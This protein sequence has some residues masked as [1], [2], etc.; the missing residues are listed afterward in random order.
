VQAELSTC[1]ERAEAAAA[2]SIGSMFD[3]VFEHMP[4]HLAEQQAECVNG[5]R[6]RKR[7]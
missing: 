4:P 2:P 3:D 1:I 7:H 6:T 5:P